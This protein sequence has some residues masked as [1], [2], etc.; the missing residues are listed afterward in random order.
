MSEESFGP[1]VG[2]Q[3]VEN[4]E[5]GLKMVNDSQFGLTGGIFTASLEKAQW[6]GER[7]EAGTAFMN[8]SDF[9]H[10]LL[11]WSGRKDTGKGVSL[12]KYGF[13]AVTQ[14]KSFNYKFKP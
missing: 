7:L 10:P 3:S 4:D 2:I 5:E 1:V 11:A 13:Y 12:S 14:S 8:K 9:L 6:F